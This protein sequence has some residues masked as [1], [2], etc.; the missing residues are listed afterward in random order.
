[1]YLSNKYSVWYHNIIQR[2]QERTLPETTYSELHH[3]IP[4]SLG[5]TD[6]ARNLARLTAK[7]HFV[8]HHLLPKMLTGQAKHKMIHA[9]VLMASVANDHQTY[10]H[11]VTARVHAYLREQQRNIFKGI[12]LSAEHKAKISKSLKGHKSPGMLGKK[13]SAATKAKQSASTKGQ[14]HSL[15]TRE[16][17]R[18]INLGKPGTMQGRKHT[19]EAREKMRNRPKKTCPH[20]GA[21]MVVNL[22]ARWHGDN[23]KLK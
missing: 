9:A 23:C 4:R 7:E 12:P 6:D 15:E 21:H 11:K 16:K 18:Q 8:C 13:H 14:T 5:G 20:C 1:M 3:V 22:Y 19:P 2:A 17:L 10:R